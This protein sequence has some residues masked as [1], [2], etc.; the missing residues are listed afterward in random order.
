MQKGEK[1]EVKCIEIKMK[2]QDE[3]ELPIFI[4]LSIP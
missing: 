3:K 4:K 2:N 1:K